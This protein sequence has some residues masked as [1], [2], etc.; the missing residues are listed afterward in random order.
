MHDGVSFNIKTLKGTHVCNNTKKNH[1]IT[2]DWIA[3]KFHDMSRI[4]PEI[5]VGALEVQLY[6]GY[7]LR[8]DKQKLY[9]AKRIALETF[10]AN[11]YECY[12][13]LYRYGHV[14]RNLN[15]GTFVQIKCNR[16]VLSENPTF[17]RIFVSFPAQKHGYLNG[18][19]PFIGLDGCHLRGRYGGVLLCVVSLD[20]NSSLFHIVVSICEGEI[21]DS[22]S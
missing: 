4:N 12:N 19:R 16:N 17:E 2:T 3:N 20:A 7:A 5:K 11:H 22:W 15:P 18:C 8:V 14:V 10:S 9:R 13:K 1:L 6:R 21:L